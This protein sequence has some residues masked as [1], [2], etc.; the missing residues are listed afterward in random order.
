M[1]FLTLVF[2]LMVIHNTLG[3]GFEV[4]LKPN[5]KD[6]KWFVPSSGQLYRP[7]QCKLFSN[8]IIDYGN[9]EIV[10]HRYAIQCRLN[11]YLCGMDGAHFSPLRSLKNNVEEPKKCE[12]C[13]KRETDEVKELEKT[14]KIQKINDA[15][16]QIENDFN[17][18]VCETDEIHKLEKELEELRNKLEQYK[19]LK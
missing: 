10:I 8:K 11:S 9:A 15:I 17:G 4:N 14:Q 5:C 6:C 7:G 1:L 3:V 13:E 19:K 18:E 12:K 2:F 16:Q